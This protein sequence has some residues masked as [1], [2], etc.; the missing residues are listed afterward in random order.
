MSGVAAAA[1]LRRSL[2]AWYD[3]EGRELPWRGGD[4]GPYEIWV[5]EVMLQQ[6]RVATA[7]TRWRTFLDRFPTVESLAEADP[8]RVCEAWA[9]LGYYRRATSLHAAATQV[10]SQYGG[11]LPQEVRLL[12]RLPGVGEYTAG[13]IA[14]IAF[15]RREPA[16]DG[17]AVRVL[18]RVLSDGADAHRSASGSAL[19]AYARQ[20]VRCRRPGDVNQALMD[21]GSVVCTPREP[22]CRR[23]PWRNACGACSHGDPECFGRAPSPRPRRRMY[24]AYALVGASNGGLWLEQRPLEGLW[25]GMWEPPSALC[26]SEDDAERELA[27]RLR[28]RLESD[29]VV[30]LQTLSHLCI[31][32]RT[33]R[34]SRRLRMRATATRRVFAPP[35]RAALSALA[36]KAVVEARKSS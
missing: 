15:G 26:D 11:R 19:R 1:R 21:L 23:C 5:S 10:C 33:Y 4:V 27:R 7:A 20:L 34:P 3:R 25:P 16:M 35:V 9:G 30:V 28:C 6:T 24:M 31:E 32:A 36:R 2:L 8:A 29:G 12:R 17:N 18:A 22:A 13:A 14:S